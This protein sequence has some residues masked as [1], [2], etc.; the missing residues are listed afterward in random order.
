MDNKE[1]QQLNEKPSKKTAWLK[2]LTILFLSLTVIGLS[3]GG[4]LLYTQHQD[5]L[6]QKELDYAVLTK[7][8]YNIQDYKDF[9]DKHPDSEYYQEVKNRHAQLYAMAEEWK[10]VARSN[11]ANEFIDFMNKYHDPHYARLCN[12][13]IDSL[14]WCAAKQQHTPEAYQRYLNQHPDGMYISEAIEGQNDVAY[15]NLSLQEDKNVFIAC[16][17]LFSAIEEG[18]EEMIAERTT[19]LMEKFDKIPS[20]GIKDILSWGLKN[21]KGNSSLSYVLGTDTQ[22]QK[23]YSDSVNYNYTTSFPLTLNALNRDGKES[24]SYYNAT[25]KMTKDYRIFFLQLDQLNS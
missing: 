10:M 18:N 7:E 25:V 16:Q 20:A 14:D 17:L 4:L 15:M 8:N 5:D 6:K 11:N 19:P 3:V 23:E 22:T 21:K 24:R 1:E 13:K 9:L 12:L 2:G